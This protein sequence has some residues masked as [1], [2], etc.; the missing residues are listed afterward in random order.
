[1]ESLGQD[2]K[3][4]TALALLPAASVPH[5][6][7]R[8][9]HRHRQL[10]LS[11]PKELQAS[12][13]GTCPGAGPCGQPSGPGL[14][15]T[16]T[17]PIRYLCPVVWLLEL[18]L[19]PPGKEG[20]RWRNLLRAHSIKRHSLQVPAPLSPGRLRTIS[21]GQ[22]QHVKHFREGDLQSLSICSLKFRKATRK[23]HFVSA[24]HLVRLPSQHLC[25]QPKRDLSPREHPEPSR[26]GT[27]STSSVEAGLSLA[28]P[29]TAS[30]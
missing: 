3:I 30:S 19:A 11:S 25:G 10:L 1:M 7:D 17:A 27:R 12:G 13:S 2:T 29:S 14:G 20:S 6:A 8:P 26:T 24:Y 9:W 18:L 28:T 5:P 16:S 22:W 23:V 21:A 15:E 4:T